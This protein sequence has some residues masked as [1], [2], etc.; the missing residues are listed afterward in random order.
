MKKIESY[1]DRSCDL[2]KKLITYNTC[3]PEGNETEL[4]EYL[5]T[6]FPSDINYKKLIHSANRSSLVIKIPGKNREKALAFVGHVDTVPYGAKENWTYEPSLPTQMG[7]RIYGR[8]SSDMKGGVAAMT[9]TAIYLLENKITPNKDILFCYTA[10]EEKTGLGACAVNMIPEMERV[11]EMIIAEPTCAQISL[12]EKGALWVRLRACGRQ[13]HGSYPELGINGIEMLF[14]LF[15]K[16]KEHLDTRM[17]QNLFG[18]STITVTNFHGGI[19][20]NILPAKAEMDLDI[21][22]IPGI[23][24]QSVLDMI[25]QEI[26]NLSRINPPLTIEMEVLNDRPAVA[27]EPA[28]PLVQKMLSAVK[29]LNMNPQL[30]ATIFYT[31]ASQIVPAH[32]IPFLILG[33][34]DDKL[35]HQG[36]EYVEITSMKAVTN[37]FIQYVTQYM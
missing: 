15:S 26:E 37:L 35:A 31:D 1:L 3:Q 4:L 12:G 34:G 27:V 21:R 6:L 23:S 7:D 28:E 17:V 13:S 19:A 32:R 9:I 8:G 5:L 14:T 10:D 36:N 24:N 16:I 30:R 22:L 25:Q 33:P 20:T 18:H 11:D 29:G 2:L